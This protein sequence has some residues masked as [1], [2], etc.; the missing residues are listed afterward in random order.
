[1]KYSPTSFLRALGGTTLLAAW[2]AAPLAAQA[3]SLSVTVVCPANPAS[4]TP[5]TLIQCGSLTATALNPPVSSYGSQ[6]YLASWTWTSTVQYA[7]SAAGP[8]G[9]PPAGA[10]CT[11]SFGASPL[12]NPTTVSMTAMSGQTGYWQV[13]PGATV[14]YR[15]NNNTV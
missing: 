4:V 12:T 8:W 7:S 5:G 6:V 15:D 1:M 14:T 2:L 3:P 9:A 11:V 13:T 10:A